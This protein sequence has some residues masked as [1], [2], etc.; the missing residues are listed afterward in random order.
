MHRNSHSPVN[1][2][3]PFGHHLSLETAIKRSQSNLLSLRKPEG[4]WNGELFVDATLICDVLAF[5]HW[6]RSV[7]KEWERKAVNRLFSMQSP[8][9]GWSLFHGGP[10]E[11]NVTIKA[12]L[13]LKLAGVPL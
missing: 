3:F 9:G 10:A 7:D 4:Y 5:H 6:D 11:V 12:Y 13:A 8:D 2:E 1:A